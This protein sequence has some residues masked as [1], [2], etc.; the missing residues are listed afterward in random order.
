MGMSTIFPTPFISRTISSE[1]LDRHA[2]A[3]WAALVTDTC[4]NDAHLDEVGV[5]RVALFS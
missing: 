4:L 5:P 1:L 3:S 2:A